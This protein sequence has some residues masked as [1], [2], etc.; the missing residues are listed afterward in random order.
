MH[1]WVCLGGPY[2]FKFFCKFYMVHPGSNVTFF[3]WFF[4]YLLRIHQKTFWCFLWEQKGKIFSICVK[5]DYFI[6]L[7]N[8]SC[9]N[10][11]FTFWYEFVNRIWR[12]KTGNVFY[13]TEVW[14]I[15]ENQYQWHWRFNDKK[16]THAKLWHTYKRLYHYYY[17]FTIARSMVEQ[18]YYSSVNGSSSYTTSMMGEWWSLE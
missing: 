14:F 8:S 6:I 17:T 2:H 5:E 7:K 4:I 10:F 9:S 3:K 15:S 16:T 1:I 11:E 18:K 12:C 13:Q